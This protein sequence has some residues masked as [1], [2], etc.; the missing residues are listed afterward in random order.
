MIFKHTSPFT[1]MLLLFF[2][3]FLFVFIH[4]FDVSNPSSVS[5]DTFTKG[6]EI[7]YVS[8]ET[9]WLDLH[10]TGVSYPSSQR[11]SY[12]CCI[13]MPDCCVHQNHAEIMSAFAREPGVS[14][15]C[16]PKTVANMTCAHNT[17][18]FVKCT[19]TDYTDMTRARARCISSTAGMAVPETILP[20][21]TKT[22]TFATCHCLCPAVDWNNVGLVMYRSMFVLPKHILFSVLGYVAGIIKPVLVTFTP[23]RSAIWP[24]H[25]R[26]LN[27]LTIN[28]CFT[29]HETVIKACKRLKAD[30]LRCVFRNHDFAVFRASMCN[31]RQF[32]MI[33]VVA[34][35]IPCVKNR[36][37]TTP[38]C[39][40]QLR[41]G[42]VS[43][44]SI[45]GGR[46]PTFS[47]EELRP[48]IDHR[49]KDIQLSSRLKFVAHN[50]R[51]VVHALHKAD[52]RVYG[53]VP[54][55]RFVLNLTQNDIKSV[56]K[57]HGIHIPCRP[58]KGGYDSSFENHS[59]PI[60]ETH[61]HH[62]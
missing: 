7:A 55:N 42:G 59:C 10:R 1:C 51:N 60:C 22:L 52:D 21:C 54:L 19:R 39:V 26:C 34:A 14:R 56:A 18:A 41:G 48:Y 47:F 29:V 43:Y 2:N 40:N 46:I 49:G 13:G 28:G 50:H 8:V 31:V 12:T 32:T 38:V 24:P 20:L 37:D 33:F 61:C 17:G 53:K 9:R 35:H 16:V 23:L 57:A 30:L 3:C 6:R 58:R 25:I 11:T 27:S 36:H 45:G 4:I 5:F 15:N 44:S 62:V